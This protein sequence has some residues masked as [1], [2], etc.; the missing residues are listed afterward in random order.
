M[1]AG[2]DVNDRTPDDAPVYTAGARGTPGGAR[3]CVVEV[4][5][6]AQYAGRDLAEHGVKTP[7]EPASTAE[8]QCQA[9]REPTRL[10]LRGEIHLGRIAPGREDPR[11]R[12]HVASDQQDARPDDPRRRARDHLHA[13]ERQLRHDGPATTGDERPD[14]RRV[15]RDDGRNDHRREPRVRDGRQRRDGGFE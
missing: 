10:E 8:Q 15:G 2:V 11:Q 9:Y 12:Q 1:L 3:R 4:L 5:G 7:R 13:R 14:G 6:C